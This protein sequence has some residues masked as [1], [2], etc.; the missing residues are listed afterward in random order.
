M[1]DERLRELERRFLES[2]TVADEAA[3]LGARVQAGEVRR[4]RVELAAILGHPAAR[5][6]SPSAPEMSLA[7][8]LRFAGEVD[9][10]AFARAG[11]ALLRPTPPPPSGWRRAL[12]GLLQRFTQLGE[13]PMEAPNL[14]ALEAVEA[15]AQA[16]GE[17]LAERSVEAGRAALALADQLEARWEGWGAPEGLLEINRLHAEVYLARACGELA[18]AVGTGQVEGFAEV[19]GGD[20]TVADDALLNQELVPWLLGRGDLLATRSALRDAM[21]PGSLEGPSS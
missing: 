15:W 13:L 17:V 3:W 16:P 6:L 5:V 21:G 11:L 14:E 20:S 9:R 10:V 8:F 19:A 12:Y 18:R 4:D 2:Q 1:S 7:E